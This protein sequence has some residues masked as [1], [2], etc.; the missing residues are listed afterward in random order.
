MRR[1]GWRM[2]RRSRPP[3]PRRPRFC[4][5]TRAAGSRRAGA[6][7]ALAPDT[8]AKFLFTSGSTGVPKAVINTQRMWCANQEMARSVLAFMQDEP[9]V[10]VEW[11]PWHHTA[12]GNKDFGL[13]L[14]NGGTMYID[15]G[16]PLPGAIEATAK[17]LAEVSPTFYFT[18][19]RGFEA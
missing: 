8:I 3:F 14:W 6:A 9:P 15:E 1:T 10:L 13:V 11:A 5:A 12:G 18:V 2:R 17:N 16:R 4:T 7:D 19:P